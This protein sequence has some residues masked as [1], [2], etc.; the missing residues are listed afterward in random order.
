M[1]NENG[2]EGAQMVWTIDEMNSLQIIE[3][4]DSNGNHEIDSVEAS[5]METTL[6]P[7]IERV[8]SV[9]VNESS[10]ENTAIKNFQTGTNENDLLQYTFFIA[11]P[12]REYSSEETNIAIT[13]YD[14]LLFVT[15]DMP[16][17]SI[18][19]ENIDGIVHSTTVSET[20]NRETCLLSIRKEI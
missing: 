6:L 10:L 15:F 8:V 13:V 1:L 12:P 19:T 9:H 2:V 14:E 17:D 16:S 18:S 4:Y 3:A 11:V 20:N 7:L 5:A